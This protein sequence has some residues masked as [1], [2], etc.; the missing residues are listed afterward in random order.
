MVRLREDC[1]F[2]SSRLDV[3]AWDG[4]LAKERS[5]FVGPDDKDA[6][7]LRARS[8]STGESIGL[9]ILFEEPLANT[10]RAALRIGYLITEAAR[11]QGFATELVTGFVEWC[12]K[13]PWVA[14]ISGGVEPD[15]VASAVVL[16]R[17]GFVL[18]VNARVDVEE[19]LL[20]L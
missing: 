14:S 10:D 16:T 11:G 2:R 8:L 9:L 12:R 3:G 7:T 5:A 17:T 1:Q 6:T 19:F 20:E 13:R 18:Q 15:N 4:S